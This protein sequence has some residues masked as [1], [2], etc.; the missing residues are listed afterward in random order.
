MIHSLR[1]NRLVPF[2]DVSRAPAEVL[3]AEAAA[4]PAPKKPRTSAPQV[5][6][7]ERLEPGGKLR[8]WRILSGQVYPCEASPFRASVLN[9]EAQQKSTKGKRSKMRPVLP[10][11]TGIT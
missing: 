2:P 1:R 11:I 5:P 4:A 7:K 9:I 10:C 3:N 8:W 6:R